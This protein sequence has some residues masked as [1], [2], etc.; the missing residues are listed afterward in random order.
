MALPP[1]AASGEGR[2]RL[3][4]SAEEQ[5]TDLH[6]SSVSDTQLREHPGTLLGA[7]SSNR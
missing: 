6:E 7:P 5:D 4:P 3:C 1:L 2:G